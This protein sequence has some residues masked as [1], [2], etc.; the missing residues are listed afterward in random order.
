MPEYDRTHD[1]V[2]RARNCSSANDHQRFPLPAI[3]AR[4]SGLLSDPR[5]VLPASSQKPHQVSG[6]PVAGDVTHWR[7]VVET[8]LLSLAD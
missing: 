4:A 3:S 2:V 7:D 8:A 6:R 5:A 1:R